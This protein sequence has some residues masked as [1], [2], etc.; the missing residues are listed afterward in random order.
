MK[1]GKIGASLATLLVIIASLA[2]NFGQ[3]AQAVADS[4]SS[5]DPQGYLINE[6]TGEILTGGAVDVVAP[7]GA[8]WQ[9]LANNSN[10]D[11]SLAGIYQWEPADSPV[12]AGDYTMSVTT[13]PAGF[14]VSSGCAPSATPYT[15]TGAT[16]T[17][18][19][20]IAFS[21]SGILDIRCASNPSYYTFSLD[22]NSG[23]VE[24][25]HIFFQPTGSVPSVC[26]TNGNV[27]GTVF[28][29]VDADG[30]YNSAVDLV[31]PHVYVSAYDANN[32]L[33]DQCRTTQAGLYS[34][35]FNDSESF[36]I[37]VANTTLPSQ[38]FTYGIPNT[39]NNINSNIIFGQA[40]ASN[41]DSSFVTTT[42]YS[43]IMIGDRVWI[44]LNDNGIQDAGEDN[45]PNVQVDLYQGTF[46]NG[47]LVGSVTTD[48]NGNFYFGG[49]NN[50]NMTGGN[51][52]LP[53]TA[54]Y[55][56]VPNSSLSNAT[57]TYVNSVPA[58]SDD[59]DSSLLEGFGGDSYLEFTTGAAGT[60][61]FSLDMGYKTRDVYLTASSTTSQATAGDIVVLTFDYGNRGSQPIL[62]IELEVSVPNNTT[63]FAASS[64]GSWSC[65]DGSGSG[66]V[67]L[68]STTPALLGYN[69]TGSI[70]FALQIQNTAVFPITIS[71]FV[72]T[73]E[74]CNS[75]VGCFGGNP[76]TS[77]HDS[78]NNSDSVVITGVSVPYVDLSVTNT[79]SVDS[80]TPGSQVSFTF[81]YA[82][83]GT[84]NATGAFMNHVVPAGTTFSLAGS[85]GSWSCPDGSING[86]VCSLI[87]GDLAVGA[88]GSATFGLI[89]DSQFSSFVTSTV[90]IAHDTEASPADVDSSN[91]N[92]T[93]VIEVIVQN[94]YEEP[95]PEPTPPPSGGGGGGGGSSTHILPIGSIN[96]VDFDPCLFNGQVKLVLNSQRAVEYRLNDSGNMSDAVW[97]EF[98]TGKNK[99]FVEREVVL[100]TDNKFSVYVE[101]RDSRGTRSDVYVVTKEVETDCGVGGYIVEPQPEELE[102][103]PVC[104]Y[105]CD[106]TTYEVYIVT[107]EGREIQLDSKYV[108]QTILENGKTRFFFEDSTAPHEQDFD[109]VVVD[110]EKNCEENVINSEVVY[111]D[112]DWHHE[113]YIKIF[114]NQEEVKDILL[115]EDSHAALESQEILSVEFEKV[116]VGEDCE[117][118]PIVEI[119]EVKECLSC[120]LIEPI[121]YIVTPAGNE[122][123]ADSSQAKVEIL[124]NGHEIVRF[125]DSTAPHEQDFNDVI[126]EITK[127]C[128]DKVI[129]AK[130]ISIEAAD[131]HEIRMKWVVDEEEIRDLQVWE[132]SHTAVNQEKSFSLETEL[133]QCVE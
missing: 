74:T 77:D 12:V 84:A 69:D 133:N 92:A 9:F 100:G 36:R 13:S 96:T 56:L 109:D 93:D 16:T 126:L 85:V 41:L 107:P 33:I 71:P 65:A 38:Y 114:A 104:E 24:N 101:F 79:R 34:F 68:A 49:P 14:Q 132:D 82:N 73:G 91:N 117:I 17:L 90:T 3:P 48:A 110:V 58:I 83:N 70:D 11:G 27:S 28:V 51:S 112:A 25:N 32:N 59:L 19:Q 76:Y 45:L 26:N 55:F 119:E 61:D 120:E 75:E 72:R 43:D 116:Y 50:L 66:T 10:F 1:I 86:T 63:F 111:V 121:F 122:Y 102:V 53:N 29:D 80:T 60:N 108:K 5:K 37:E 115:W 54:Y 6:F 15:P 67:C 113:V 118:E 20:D 105:D 81:D 62:G 46:S 124:S 30:T 64:T 4:Y 23:F 87:I 21:P 99:I 8:T 42:S 88:S 57:Y 22:N 47:T 129:N 127:D 125:E 44:D 128:A 89:V 31:R 35:S 97:Q 103:L 18:G 7:T 106:K 130:I 40:P 123:R 94:N 52:L 98:P 131:H 39:A 78:T 95:T 2:S